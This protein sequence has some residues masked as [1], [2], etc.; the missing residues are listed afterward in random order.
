M[1]SVVLYRWPPGKRLV[2]RF[3]YLVLI[4]RN[5]QPRMGKKKSHALKGHVK[6]LSPVL[7]TWNFNRDLL[8]RTPNH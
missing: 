3:F 1:E 4:W 5:L 8:T 6:N 7:T 2:A